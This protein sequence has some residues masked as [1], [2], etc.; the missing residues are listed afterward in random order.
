MNHRSYADL[1]RPKVS[2]IVVCLLLVVLI[3]SGWFETSFKVMPPES[4]ILGYSPL[5]FL[6]NQSFE[7]TSLPALIISAALIITVGGTLFWMNEQF[8]FI[9]VRTLLP[10][11]FFVII[12]SL[13][14]RPHTLNIGAILAFIF[15]L[16]LFS[17]FKLCEEMSSN[18]ARTKFNMGL[19][20]GLSS[21]LAL[22][23]LAYIVPLIF[24]SF[25]T[26]TL[27]IKGMLALFLGFL[28]PPFYL[29]L[30][31]AA[32]DNLFLVEIYLNSW[33][34]GDNTL[35]E[36]TSEPF[37]IYLGI[38]TLLAL[39]SLVKVYFLSEHQSIKTRQETKYICSNFVITLLLVLLRP[40]DVGLLL[41]IYIFFSSILIGQSFSSDFN[42][43][44]KIMWGI[45]GI[46]SIL[47]L[48]FPTYD[49]I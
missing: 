42:L 12:V 31:L 33:W 2:N 30:A 45:F 46:A 35:L 29:L 37:L 26:Q 11:F 43:P 24:F 28:V 49:F 14:M 5:T 39:I 19:L 25:Q 9:P 48:F 3:W 1:I 10:T 15:A 36:F 40:S 18:V 23:T 6:L 17:S 21:L 13:L 16:R 7:V 8:S 4:L 27:S 44:T 41:P 47:Y 20:L 34:L 38:I 32:T 22:S